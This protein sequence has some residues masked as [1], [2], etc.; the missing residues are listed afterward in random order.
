[1]RTEVTDR[2]VLGEVVPG[3]H[4][5]LTQAL[6]DVLTVDGQKVRLPVPVGHAAPGIATRSYFHPRGQVLRRT[7]PYAA[8]AGRN[9]L[10][11]GSRVA[12]IR[13]EASAAVAEHDR[14]LTVRG[15]R[16][17]ADGNGELAARAVLQ[18]D[19]GAQLAVRDTRPE[20]DRSQTTC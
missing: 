17:L 15:T 5:H 10:I 7:D 13:G 4:R 14:P 12:G 3:A 1:H 2:A 19:R 11:V 18:A 20:G 6:E 9:E 16:V 8:P